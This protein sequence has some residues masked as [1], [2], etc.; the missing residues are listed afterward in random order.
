MKGMDEAIPV[1]TSLGMTRVTD[2][3]EGDSWKVTFEKAD[4]KIMKSTIMRRV[5]PSSMSVFFI[6]L[7]SDWQV[8]E[9]SYY[10]TRKK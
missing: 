4:Q 5:Y 10:I 1:V 6:N 2:S 8:P 7:V 3:K 9:S